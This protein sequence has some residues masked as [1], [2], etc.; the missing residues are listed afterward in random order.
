VKLLSAK[1]E[2]FKLLHQHTGYRGFSVFPKEWKPLFK[3]YF[4]A[5]LNN[6]EDKSIGCVVF[7]PEPSA[8][9]RK[10]ERPAVFSGAAMV[11]KMSLI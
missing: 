7:G 3:K 6:H 4:L 9:N 2:K 1:L 11:L 8:F 10:T 5:L